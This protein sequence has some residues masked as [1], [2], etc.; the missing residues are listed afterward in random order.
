[1]VLSCCVSTGLFI[2]SCLDNSF[3]DQQSLPHIGA[4]SDQIT[5][6]NSIIEVIS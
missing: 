2:L 3:L 6:L 1:M 4:P 5:P